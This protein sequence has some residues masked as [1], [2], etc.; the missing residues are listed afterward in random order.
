MSESTRYKIKDFIPVSGY[1]LVQPLDK[2]SDEG[3]EITADEFPQL[4]KCLKVG[5]SYYDESRK[6]I[7]DSPC[8]VGDQIVHSAGGFETFKLN[9]EE[10][11][12][13]KFDRVLMV[14]K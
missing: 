14:M 7:V 9:G 4:A 13:I 2:T 5:E 1:I 11:R 6:M 12:I 10:F 8:K 3:I